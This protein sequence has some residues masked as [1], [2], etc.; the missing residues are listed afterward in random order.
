MDREWERVAVRSATS[1]E[2]GS[3][4]RSLSELSVSTSEGFNESSLL[5]GVR[6]LSPQMLGL[7]WGVVEIWWRTTTMVASREKF[8][9]FVTTNPEGIRRSFKVSLIRTSARQ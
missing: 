5:G 2:G 1:S 7:W 3:R 4:L 6:H 9:P 8:R